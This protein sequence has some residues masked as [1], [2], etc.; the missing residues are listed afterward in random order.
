MTEFH[1]MYTVIIQVFLTQL[2]MHPSSHQLSVKEPITL[3]IRDL[4]MHSLLF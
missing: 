4:H 3:E 1:K 2:K